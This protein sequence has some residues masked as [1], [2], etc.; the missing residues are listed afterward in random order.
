MGF[1]FPAQRG[2][3][4]ATAISSKVTA[5]FRRHRIEGCY[6]RCRHTYGTGLLQAGLNLR[7]VQT[8]MR[9]ESL[10]STAA[11]LAVDEDERAAAIRLLVA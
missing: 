5:H 10:T 4:D 9:H 2:H 7:I 11:Y 1:W 8:L 3:V 6:H